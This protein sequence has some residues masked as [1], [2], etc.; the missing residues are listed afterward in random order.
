MRQISRLLWFG[1]ASC[2]LGLMLLGAGCGD[3]SAVKLSE[4][5]HQFAYPAGPGDRQLSEDPA[6][7]RIYRASTR[8]TSG[9]TALGS[10]SVAYAATVIEQAVVRAKPRDGAPEVAPIR[11]LDS[12]GLPEVVAVIGVRS[13]GACAAAWYRVRLSVLPNGTTGWVRASAVKTYRVQ[14]RIVIDLSQ[15]HLRLFRSGKLAFEASVAVGSSATPTPRGHYFVNERYVL[16]DASGPFGPN[17]L[18]ISAH[19]N[20]LQDSWVE[21]GPIAI[22]GTNEPGSIG[23][24]ASHGCIRIANNM[25]RLM[26]PLAPAGTPVI[27]K[28]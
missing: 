22:H 19:S 10:S 18:G 7:P 1:A 14:S 5:S 13:S 2:C 15:R 11:P 16:P 3:G 23:T 28:A 27:V 17:A 8:C 21:N 26:F 6:D 25:M 12:R 20:A 9:S 4:D 24:A